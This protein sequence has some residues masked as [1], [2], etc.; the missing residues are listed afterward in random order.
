MTPISVTGFN[1]DVVVENSAGAPP[2][3]GVA[4]TF[5]SGENRGFYQANLTTKTHGLPVNGG[6][7]NANDGT[8]FQLQPYTANN[9]LMI[10]R[11]GPH[12]RHARAGDAADL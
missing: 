6:I 5:N 9:A 4:F 7:T 11:H 3:G 12:Q 1:R 2:Y 10:S 8:V